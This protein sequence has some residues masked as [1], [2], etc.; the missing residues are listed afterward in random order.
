MIW[1][2]VIF[3]DFLV[4][5]KTKFFKCHF[6]S[7]NFKKKKEN[8]KMIYYY[9]V[10][11]AI[12]VLAQKLT[13]QFYLS[14][15]IGYNIPWEIILLSKTMINVIYVLHWFYFI[16]IIYFTIS[17]FLIYMHFPLGP[18]PYFLKSLKMFKFISLKH[19]LKHYFWA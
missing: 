17:C 9:N 8:N 5:I 16:S 11:F 14:Y 7:I 6:L 10:L 1:E 13:Y 12:L 4:C 18:P 19:H 3:N 2:K 15:L